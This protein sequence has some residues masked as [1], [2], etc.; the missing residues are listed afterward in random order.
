MAFVND[1]KIMDVFNAIDVHTGEMLIPARI[2]VGGSFD[3]GKPDYGQC[4]QRVINTDELSYLYKIPDPRMDWPQAPGY[5]YHD[6][7][8]EV[9]YIISGTFDITYPDGKKD[10]IGPGNA[11]HISKGQGYRFEGADD[12]LGAAYA[13]F[14]S[15][16]VQAVSS[17]PF[18]SGEIK[19]GH[20]VKFVPDIA[21]KSDAPKGIEMAL[22]SASD[23]VVLYDVVVKPGT[24]YPEKG[25]MTNN[26]TQIIVVVSGSGTGIYPDKDYSFVKETAAYHKAGQPYK[27]ANTGSEDLHMLVA[28]NAKDEK[29][30]SSKAVEITDFV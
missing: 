10:H 28:F 13:V 24:V 30:I 15:K 5:G 20:E 2:Y 29:T 6:N 3:G 25:F 23:D 4:M 12:D 19:D 26:C 17:K 16:K 21:K 9:G 18:E 22:I 8:D 27:Y 14:Y 1:Y 11:Y 7:S